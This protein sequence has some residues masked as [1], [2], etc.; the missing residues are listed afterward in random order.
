MTKA[1]KPIIAWLKKKKKSL[2][3]RRELIYINHSWI[4]KVKLTVNKKFIY[5]C[6]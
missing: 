2:N 1:K 5:E 6:Y 4:K 3:E